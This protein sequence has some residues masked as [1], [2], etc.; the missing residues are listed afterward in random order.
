MSRS[1]QRG[2]LA[3]SRERDITTTTRDGTRLLA[4]IYRPSEIQTAPVLLRRTPYGNQD[5]DL[6]ETPNE[7]RRLRASPTTAWGNRSK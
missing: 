1:D 6:A 2:P 7:N 3:R 4:E 5:N